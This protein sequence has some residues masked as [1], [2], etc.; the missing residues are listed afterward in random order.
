M[1]TTDEKET[2]I[3][4]GMSLIAIPQGDSRTFSGFYY[5]RRFIE[6]ILNHDDLSFG[7]KKEIIEKLALLETFVNARYAHIGSNI[8]EN[9][10]IGDALQ[11]FKVKNDEDFKQRIQSVDKA[12]Q[13]F[14]DSAMHP[15]ASME[16]SIQYEMQRA[17]RLE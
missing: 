5:E 13:A 6:R 12:L 2:L 16:R 17:G 9:Q 7:C 8:A 4:L 10:M 15:F 1:N 3:R 14:E 11:I